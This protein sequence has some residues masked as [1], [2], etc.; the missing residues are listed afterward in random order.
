MLPQGFTVQTGGAADIRLAIAGTGA[1]PRANSTYIITA[2][3]VGSIDSQEFSIENFV[4]P[5]FAYQNGNPVPTEIVDG[6][7]GSS[8]AKT[9]SPEGH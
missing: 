6:P 4:E 3:N 1:K 9:R 8:F 7:A 5:W 2:S